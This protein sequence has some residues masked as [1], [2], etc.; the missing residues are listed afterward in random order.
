MDTEYVMMCSEELGELTPLEAFAVNCHSEVYSQIRAKVD[1]NERMDDDFVANTCRAAVNDLP[2]AAR[3]FAGVVSLCRANEVLNAV[4]E[5]LSVYVFQQAR[6]DLRAEDAGNRDVWNLQPITQ[7]IFTE[8]QGVDEAGVRQVLN[9]DALGYL[10]RMRADASV[11]GEAL[12]LI[13]QGDG[14]YERYLLKANRALTAR[15]LEI[16]KQTPQ[17]ADGLQTMKELGLIDRVKSRSYMKSV[18]D[19]VSAA[20]RAIKKAVKLFEGAGKEPA[21]MKFLDGGEIELSH[22]S[23]SLKFAVKPVAMNDW[24]INRSREDY[25]A[26]TPFDLSLLTKDDVFIG[27]LCVYFAGTPVLDQLF[28]LMLF[29]DSGEEELI[30]EKAN[31]FGWQRDNLKEIKHTSP[32]LKKKIDACLE[33]SKPVRR[34][35]GV[36]VRTENLSAMISQTPEM[37][38]HAWWSQTYEAQVKQWC[39]TWIEDAAVGMHQFVKAGKAVERMLDSARL[40]GRQLP[41]LFNAMRGHC[42]ERISAAYAYLDIREQQAPAFPLAAPPRAERVPA[43]LQLQEV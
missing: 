33:A 18:S 20:K 23:S 43:P 9:R 5:R 24:L 11:F 14:E 28:S 34:G 38:A 30:L 22:P 16:Q 31:L 29:V 15:Y 3:A 13:S 40:S 35:D 8:A 27:K 39:H 42:D 21:L 32:S 10:E 37:R 2:P 36:V 26:H 7:N 25:G 41:L 1:S 17:T 6:H 19:K 12:E 4:V